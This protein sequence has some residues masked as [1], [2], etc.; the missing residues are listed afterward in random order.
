MLRV[1]GWPWKGCAGMMSGK[2]WCQNTSKVFLRLLWFPPTH[3]CPLGSLL[4]SPGSCLV[5]LTPLGNLGEGED[6]G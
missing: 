1:E 4:S 3:C 5:H 2:I 6:G